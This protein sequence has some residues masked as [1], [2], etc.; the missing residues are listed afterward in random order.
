MWPS[1]ACMLVL[2]K[3]CVWLTTYYRSA[4]MG[5]DWWPP[6]YHEIIVS[7]EFFI[8][9]QAKLELGVSLLISASCSSSRVFKSV[10]WDWNWLDASWNKRSKQIC[11]VMKQYI[12][13][14]PKPFAS[15]STWH[16]GANGCKACFMME[17]QIEPTLGGYRCRVYYYEVKNRLNLIV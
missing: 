2:I 14:S 6:S 1:L 9:I 16:L 4:P 5:A 7:L 10:S 15:N 3:N 12:L 8:F 13:I 11:T 17:W